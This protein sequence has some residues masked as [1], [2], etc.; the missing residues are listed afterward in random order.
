MKT[1][2]TIAKKE[3][4]RFLKDKRLLAGLFLPGILIF[5]IYSLLGGAMPSMMGVDE[6][7]TPT[8]YVYNLPASL[9]SEF[10]TLEEQ[11]VWKIEEAT[12][13]TLP[14]LLEEIKSKDS[15]F[16]ILVSFPKNFAPS[17]L[18]ENRQ[19]ISVSYN[20]SK[21]E[22]AMAYQLLS[23]VLNAQFSTAL[24]APVDFA[25]EEDLTAMI[26]STVAP[27]LLV[28]FLFAGCSS[29]VPESIAGEKERGTLSAMLVT[30]VKRSHVALGKIFALSALSV[31]SGACSFLGLYF[32]LPKLMEGSGLSL[33]AASYGASD[34]A[35]ILLIVLSTVLVVVSALSVASTLAK[36]VKESAALIGPL[37]LVPLLMGFS[38]L[39][40]GTGEGSIALYFIPLYNSIR[41]LGG[42]FSFAASPL[43]VAVA[44]LSNLVW[45]T[46]LSLLIAK[47]FDNE[48]VMFNK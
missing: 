21:T 30:P 29:I 28:T 20:S 3:F 39:L 44:C 27:M 7:Y 18:P 12:D 14:T 1:V 8:V 47:L 13:S 31:A 22:S 35:M 4:L 24:V 48:R 17:D 45:A 2:W 36:S 23:G 19:I 5:V 34:F 10:S 46:L 41:A 9:E 26:F 42:I 32:S 15:A 40:T 25:T 43:R 37:S 16:D 38:T 33:S 11:G 6:N